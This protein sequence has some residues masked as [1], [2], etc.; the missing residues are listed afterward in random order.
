MIRRFV[1]G[2]ALVCGLLALGCSSDSEPVEKG[3]STARGDSAIA[4]A[5]MIRNPEGF[6]DYLMASEEVP[7]GTL[8]TSRGLELP[9]GNYYTDDSAVY[10]WNFE[11]S[12]VQRYV[13]NRS[14]EI[15]LD[16]ELSMSAYTGGTPVFFSATEAYFID[17]SDG[18]LIKFNPEAMELTG[19]IEVP[20][21]V[22][23]GLVGNVNRAVKVGDRILATIVYTDPD[24]TR[25]AEDSTVAIALEPAS[26]QPL[27]ILRDER[28]VSADGAFADDA[29]NFYAIAD[30]GAGYFSLVQGQSVD[31]RL[32]RVKAG[33][34]QVDPDYLLD[35]G[36]LLGAHTLNGLWPYR[37]TKFVV[38]AWTGS[39]DEVVTA[40]DLDVKP[41]WEWF[42]VD[43]ETEEFQKIS[44]LGH[45]TTSYS[46]LRFVVDEQLY[47][48]QYIVDAEDYN[49]AHVELYRLQANAKVEKVAE[50]TRG[51]M[52]V[53][54][55]VRIAD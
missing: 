20:E 6:T 25:A 35:L 10:Y 14:L 7:T 39:A 13:V 24:F 2:A 5:L 44:E 17:V 29:G 23:D 26:D 53:M 45:S 37:D 41:G 30:G 49:A 31:P 9:G 11:K 42:V 19:E 12:S 55:R 48:Q 43:A 28:A 47:L 3:S 32:I 27:Q 33:E 4:Y 36:E 54:T 50:S 8:D 52:R 38:Q 16:G 51:D 46:L 22:R 34:K 18:L 40:D 1:Q 15:V 21:L